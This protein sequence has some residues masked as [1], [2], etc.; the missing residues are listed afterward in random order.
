MSQELHDYIREAKDKG[1]EH[2][3]IKGA[4][5]DAG[6]HPHVVDEAMDKHHEPHRDAPAPAPS[7]RAESVPSYGAQTPVPVVYN[8]TARGVE[9]FLML[10]SL[11]IAAI[12][13]G[14]L[15]HNIAGELFNDGGTNIFFSG[16]MSFAGSALV[17][18]LPLFIFFFLR[19]KKA[20]LVSPRLR[21]DP[22][23]RR[24]FQIAVF[25]S[26][27]VG[28]FSLI[29]YVYTFFNSGNDLYA[30]DS[31]IGLTIADMIITLGIAGG[32]F[33]YFWLDSQRE[34]NR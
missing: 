24:A 15:L 26:F 10:I 21:H 22:S 20:E 34:E 11:A 33:A 28:V 18:S 4:L 16:V 2:E 30:A 9:Y 8:Y 17:V 13:L 12:S 31:N 6:W 14:T 1:A 19:L 29:G 3:D 7:L 25:G 27:L 5:V 32:I 23:R